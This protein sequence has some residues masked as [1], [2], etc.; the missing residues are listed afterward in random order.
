MDLQCIHS[1]C[2]VA[3]AEWRLQSGT[4]RVA[5]AEWH[6]QSGTCSSMLK[7]KCRLSNF[8]PCPC[9]HVATVSVSFTEN[10]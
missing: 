8:L 1:V 9:I 10:A 5:L 6:L 4:C 7:F 2:R 3:L